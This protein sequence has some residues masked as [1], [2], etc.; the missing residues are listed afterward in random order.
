MKISVI[1][2]NFN[3]ARYLEKS[4]NS[5]I[6]QSYLPDQVIFID[7]ASTDDSISI[8]NKLS[9]NCKFEFLLLR[10]YS[11]IGTV[12]SIN[13]ALQSVNSDFVLFLSASDYISNQLIFEARNDLL[14]CNQKPGIWASRAYRYNLAS[15]SL[16]VHPS[17]VIYLKRK[18]LN[19]FE[20]I[21]IANTIGSWFMGSS[22]LFNVNELKK[23]GNLN[24]TL[25]GLADLFAAFELSASSGG[26]YNPKPLSYMFIHD[27]GYF[28]K[29][30]NNFD[31]LNTSLES[32]FMSIKNYNLFDKKFFSRMKKRVLFSYY[33]DYFK[34]FKILNFFKF[35]RVILIFLIFLRFRLFD[36][37]YIVKFRIFNYLLYK[38]EK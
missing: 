34:K 4:F 5:L 9:E 38:I 3:D 31:N 21:S 13:I 6:N 32:Y 10:N 16:F 19:S 23:I 27:D 37:Y 2:P 14:S 26:F 18:Y 33:S 30:L 8:I 1:I 28:S 20:C 25:G 36:F 35:T 17:P 29:S 7:D 22:L 15:H 11:N 24:E 12:K